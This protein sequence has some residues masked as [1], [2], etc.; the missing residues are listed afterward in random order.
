YPVALW[1]LQQELNKFTL[2]YGNPPIFIY[3][4]GQRTP[5]NASLQDESRV[6]YLHGYIGATL[7]AL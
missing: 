2:L 4:N 7:D 3:E 1:D 6:K 5:S